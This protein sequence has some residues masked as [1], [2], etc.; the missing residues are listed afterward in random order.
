MNPCCML[1]VYD[2]Y[3][4]EQPLIRHKGAQAPPGWRYFDCT[5]PTIVEMPHLGPQ[6]ISRWVCR[7]H[8]E[9]ALEGEQIAL[10]MAE[11]EFHQAQKSFARSKK[12]VAAL[13]A[14]L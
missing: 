13:K 3:G 8:A 11:K 10:R 7:E 5:R 9:I 4:D 14:A 1:R 2:P 12:R 6:S